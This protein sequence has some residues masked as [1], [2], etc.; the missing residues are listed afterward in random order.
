MGKI[1]N[2]AGQKFGRLTVL[3]LIDKNKWR[4]TRWL[5]VCDCGKEK[6]ILSSS[7]R[8]GDTNSCG[9]LQKERSFLHGHANFNGKSKTYRSWAS[10]IQRCTNPNNENYHNYG[11]RGITICKQWM[12]FPNFLRDMGNS[13]PGKPTLGRC[14]SD[15]NYCKSNCNWETWKQQERNTS[16]NHLLQHD[17][18]TQCIAAWAEEF[19]ILATTLRMRLKYGWSIEKALMTSVRKKKNEKIGI[20]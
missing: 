14:N 9:C 5:C 1:I 11:G 4:N 18:R 2:L 6:I 19:G 8:N 15:G 20:V 7:L 3:S 13:P 10:M 16:R 12:K 17:D